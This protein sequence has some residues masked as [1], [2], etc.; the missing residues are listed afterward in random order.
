MQMLGLGS[1]PDSTVGTKQTQVHTLTLI[2][3]SCMSLGKSLPLQGPSS[4]VKNDPLT[5]WKG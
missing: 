3:I 1:H 4:S 2:Q 5:G